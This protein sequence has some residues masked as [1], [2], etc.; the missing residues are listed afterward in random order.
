MNKSLS[1]QQNLGYLVAITVLAAAFVLIG[2]TKTAGASCMHTPVNE[3]AP[4]LSGDNSE[5]ST[6]TVTSGDWATCGDPS[7]EYI[8]SRDDGTVVADNFYDDGTS[9]DS[10]TVTG[11]DAGHSF[12]VD[13]V[14]STDAAGNYD[15]LSDPL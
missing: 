6:L 3:N 10:Y 13:V 8:W 12:T 4:V 1:Y 15:A 14:A 5:G 2:I 9:Q 11:D 7:F